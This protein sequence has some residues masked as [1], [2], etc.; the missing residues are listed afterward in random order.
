[1]QRA[2]TY[3]I[4]KIKDLTESSLDRRYIP[5]YTPD[6]RV[7]EA[8]ERIACNRTQKTELTSE[9]IVVDGKAAERE[10][11]RGAVVRERWER[12]ASATRE[13]LVVEHGGR[14]CGRGAGVRRPRRR[15]LR[16]KRQHPT[17]PAAEPAAAAAVAYRFRSPFTAPRRSLSV[18]FVAGVNRSWRGHEVSRRCE[19]VRERNERRYAPTA[20]ASN[21]STTTC[22]SSVVVARLRFVNRKHVQRT[23]LCHVRALGELCKCPV[24][25]A[26][27]VVAVVARV[28]QSASPP[29]DRCRRPQP[30]SD[31]Q[32]HL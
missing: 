24:C 9:R 14:G 11:R 8:Y 31:R 2:L 19:Q 15:R 22:L 3:S 26:A 16:Q 7:L 32:R 21:V 6:G 5:V 20:S 12:G 13:E 25:R 4:Q 17:C 30:I 29:S 23:L 10:V 18:E 27:L 28:D 1:M